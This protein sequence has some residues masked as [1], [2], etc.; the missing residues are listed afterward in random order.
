MYKQRREQLAQALRDPEMIE[1]WDFRHYH[2]C[3]CAVMRQLWPNDMKRISFVGN[4]EA[5]LGIKDMF[6]ID[7]ANWLH[8]REIRIEDVTPEMVAEALE[9]WN[10]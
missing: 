6:I 7:G 10:E 3:A 1:D 8:N 9:N 5:Y 4:Y 2:S